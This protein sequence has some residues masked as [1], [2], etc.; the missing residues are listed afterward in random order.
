MLGFLLLATFCVVIG[1]EGECYY[2]YG[3]NLYPFASTCQKV[4]KVLE[5][6]LI[7]DEANLYSLK[8]MFFYAANADP[9][10]LIVKYNISFGENIIKDRPPNCDGA[11]RQMTMICT[12]Q[13]EVTHGWTPSGVYYVIGPLVLNKMQMPF[14]FMIL[15]IIHSLC[16]N[17]AFNSPELDS[18]LW[19]GSYDLPTVFLNLDIT[20]LPCIPSATVFHSTLKELTAYVSAL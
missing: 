8:K 4:F 12:I 11:G 1:A 5:Q 17:P 7:Q 2:S 20:T 3:Y 9:M 14:P 13:T 16:K 15:R 6:S 10:L 18:F 19:D